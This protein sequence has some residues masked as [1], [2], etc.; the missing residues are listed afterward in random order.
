MT[1]RSIDVERLQKT[2]I[3]SAGVI[4]ELY[5]QEDYILLLWNTAKYTFSI[6]YYGKMNGDEIIKL[7]ESLTEDK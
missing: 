7:A 1:K 5:S 2:E 3:L 6:D 4:Y